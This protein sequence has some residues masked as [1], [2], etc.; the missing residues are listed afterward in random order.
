MNEMGWIPDPGDPRDH[1]F[2]LGS[3]LEADSV[4]HSFFLTHMGDPFY[5]SP[6]G[7]C[8]A[9]AVAKGIYASHMQQGVIEPEPISRMALWYLA[10][11]II[12]NQYE[13]KGCHIRDAFKVLNRL[14]FCPESAWP[15]NRAVGSDRTYD[16]MPPTM[17]FRDAY[18][19]RA[20]GSKP[21]C[22]HRITQT[23][24][25][26]LQ[27]I[28]EAIATG[29]PVIFG[30]KVTKDFT[31]N[32]LPSGPID[33]PDGEPIAGGHAMVVAGYSQYGFEILNSWGSGWGSNGWCVFSNEYI[34]DP[35]TRDLWVVKAAPTFGQDGQT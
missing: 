27:A 26:R 15:Y 28:R 21:V 8:V 6:F 4:P 32:K 30:T 19:Q 29:R 34:K 17:A 9:Q 31:R 11:A 14:G 33:P 16:K 10:R 5:Q 18:D 25:D 35:R 7:S 13:D 12:G 23:G 1:A 20:G 3:D 24:D 2:A 22:Y